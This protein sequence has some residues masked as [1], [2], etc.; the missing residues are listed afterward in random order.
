MQY[1]S[2]KAMTVNSYPVMEITVNLVGYTF[3]KMHVNALAQKKMKA[4]AQKLK[5]A[6][7]LGSKGV[8]VCFSC[9]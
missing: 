6:E 2:G 5:Y 7:E 1:L 9:L 8:V 3:E 4:S